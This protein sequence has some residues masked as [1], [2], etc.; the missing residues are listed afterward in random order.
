MELRAEWM[1]DTRRRR[2]WMDGGGCLKTR[3]WILWLAFVIKSICGLR[4]VLYA[5]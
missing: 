2:R 4:K 3:R 5:R 1:M